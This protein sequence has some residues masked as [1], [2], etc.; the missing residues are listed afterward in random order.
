MTQLQATTP[1]LGALIRLYLNTSDGTSP[2][3]DDG[4]DVAV[5][6]E[7]KL[8]NLH[9]IGNIAVTEVAASITEVA[10]GEIWLP[11]RYVGFTLWNASGATISATSTE[12]FLVLTPIPM[13]FQAA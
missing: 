8:N 5:S 9:H 10:S 4:G 7:D 2:N 6:A 3:H 13:E 12:T 11:H 1:A